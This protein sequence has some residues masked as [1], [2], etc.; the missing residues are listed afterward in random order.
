MPKLTDLELETCAMALRAYARLR[1]QDAKRVEGVGVREV[2]ERDADRAAQ[3]AE[4]FER[5]RK[6]R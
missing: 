6:S 5:A 3:L 1:E 4:R 2:I